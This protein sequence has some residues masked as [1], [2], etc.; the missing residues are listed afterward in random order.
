MTNF[1]HADVDEYMPLRDVV[2]KTLRQAILRGEL[3]NSY[4]GGYKDA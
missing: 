4:K 1:S 3:Q 2:F